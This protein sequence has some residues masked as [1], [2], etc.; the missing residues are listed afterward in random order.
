MRNPLTAAAAAVLT[1]AALAGC[2][3]DSPLITV[4]GTVTLTRSPD[5]AT[6]AWDIP[7]AAD[8][9]NCTG[10]GTYRDLKPGSPVHVQTSAGTGIATG[11][12]GAGVAAVHRAATGDD[13]ADTCTLPFTV[14]GV[15]YRDAY[16]IEVPPVPSKPVTAH[17]A[18]TGVALTAAPSD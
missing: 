9:L 1:A 4:R 11:R 7:G 2:G 14:D 6:F 10:F 13:V 5:A 3:D 15:P 16:R 12:L 18:E 8:R 17:Q